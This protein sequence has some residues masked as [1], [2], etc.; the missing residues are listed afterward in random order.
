[1]GF[2]LE[3]GNK[4]RDSGMMRVVVAGVVENTCQTHGK[5]LF[6][7]SPFHS[8]GMEIMFSCCYLGFF[9]WLISLV[10]GI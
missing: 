7:G 9:T 1:M 4:V 2:G 6:G 5:R 3:S 8:A 10:R